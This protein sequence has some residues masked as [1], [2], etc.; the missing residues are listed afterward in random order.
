MGLWHGLLDS[1]GIYIL[2][3]LADKD[4]MSIVLFSLMIGGMVGIIN[5]NGGMAGIVQ[6]LSTMLHRAN[7]AR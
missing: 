1:V 2:N 6:S 7:A 3:A 5:Q 4:H